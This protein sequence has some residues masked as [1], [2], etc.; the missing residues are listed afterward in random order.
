MFTSSLLQAAKEKYA[1]LLASNLEDAGSFWHGGHA[2]C[3]SCRCQVKNCA[4][5]LSAKT[6]IVVRNFSKEKLRPAASVTRIAFQHARHANSI[7]ERLQ[8]GILMATVAV[9]ETTEEA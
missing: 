4:T 2:Q 8:N 9:L 3:A 5:G 7:C 6:S 1:A